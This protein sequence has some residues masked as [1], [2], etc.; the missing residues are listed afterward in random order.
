MVVK[1]S[2]VETGNT[3]NLA[4]DMMTSSSV[5]R[6]WYQSTLTALAL[7]F[8]VAGTFKLAR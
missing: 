2:P 5:M 3:P 1:Q 4:S 8:R 6:I 7:S